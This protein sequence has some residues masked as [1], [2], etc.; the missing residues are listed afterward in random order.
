MS[1]GTSGPVFTPLPVECRNRVSLFAPF[2]LICPDQNRARAP[3]PSALGFS[4]G[5]TKKQGVGLFLFPSIFP[6]F[7][8]VYCELRPVQANPNFLPHY[9]CRQKG[10]CRRGIRTREWL[11]CSLSPLKQ[12]PCTG[13]LVSLFVFSG[14]L[15]FSASFF[16]LFTLFFPYSF[17]FLNF[18]A[19]RN[20]L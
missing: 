14:L 19:K 2:F 7:S 16:F 13:V 9:S 10:N 1:A 18:S 20:P 8:F 12:G 17:I 5:E 4:S 6:Q 15:F 11:R 3:G